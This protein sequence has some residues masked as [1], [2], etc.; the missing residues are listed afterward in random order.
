MIPLEENFRGYT[1]KASPLRTGNGR[2]S[3]CTL[4]RRVQDI[5]G[6]EHRFHDDGK[7]SY[8]LEIEAAKECINLGKNLI[9]RNLVGF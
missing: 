4:I 5:P 8:L 6:T 3:V 1:I 2:W 9:R 7:L